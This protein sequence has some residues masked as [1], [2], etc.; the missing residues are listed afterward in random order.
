M[1]GGR[2]AGARTECDAI[3]VGAND[4]EEGLEGTGPRKKWMKKE[5]RMDELSGF[6][7][8]MRDFWGVGLEEEGWKN[9][10]FDADVDKILMVGCVWI[11]RCRLCLLLAF[12]RL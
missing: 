4:Q 10:R 1:G 12:L 6:P 9:L 8:K 11:V 2:V 7:R 3:N 5:E